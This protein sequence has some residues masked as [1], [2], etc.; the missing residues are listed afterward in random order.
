M[1]RK[2][3]LVLVRTT[4]GA[5]GWHGFED[6]PLLQLFFKRSLVSSFVR[7]RMPRRL[8]RNLTNPER[9]VRQI[10]SF[11]MRFW[12]VTKLQLLQKYGQSSKSSGLALVLQYDHFET[13]CRTP[14]SRAEYIK[15][16][17][18]LSSKFAP[19]QSGRR[20]PWLQ[21]SPTRPFGNFRRKKNYF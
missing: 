11:L 6:N 17:A 19:A 2:S 13:R 18:M 12:K 10:Y 16:V 15:I 3:F 20:E 9:L 21:F 4:A 14:L 1:T 7:K 5:K 8:S